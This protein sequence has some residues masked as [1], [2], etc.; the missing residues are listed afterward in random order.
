MKKILILLVIVGGITFTAKSSHIVG[1]DTRFEQTGANSYN[2]NIRMFRFC[3][4]ISY[5]S[6]IAPK[7]PR[8]FPKV[9][10]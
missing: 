1:G 10:V 5:P 4:G 2:I 3:S 9:T 8:A 6:T 7:A